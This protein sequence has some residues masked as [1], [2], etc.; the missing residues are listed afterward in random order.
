MNKKLIV[1]IS[2]IVVG[3]VFYL[4]FYK[5]YMKEDVGPNIDLSNSKPLT[6]SDFVIDGKFVSKDDFDNFLATLTEMPNTRINGESQRGLY[7]IY[8]AVDNSGVKYNIKFD[9]GEASINSDLRKD[10]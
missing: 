2:I 3:A 5:N 4:F 10:E 6:K 8:T 7:S 1:L 9:G